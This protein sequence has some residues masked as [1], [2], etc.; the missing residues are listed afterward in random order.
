[1]DGP[2]LSHERSCRSCGSRQRKSRGVEIGGSKGPSPPINSG[3]GAK[4][5]QLFIEASNIFK[6]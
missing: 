3:Q 1:M 5:G 4:M 2:F 6:N